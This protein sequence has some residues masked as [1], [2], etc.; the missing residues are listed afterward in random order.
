MIGSNAGEAVPTSSGATASI[1]EVSA[2]PAWPI[3]PRS[4]GK[5]S[6]QQGGLDELPVVHVRARLRDGQRAEPAAVAAVAV[7]DHHLAEPGAQAADDLARQL[8]QEL[9][10]ERD[11]DPEPYVVRAE[12]RP[13][14]G[15]DDR[16]GARERRRAQRDRL[17]EQRVGADGEVLAVLLERADGEDADRTRLPRSAASTRDSSLRRWPFIVS[18]SASRR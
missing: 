3:E 15:C 4:T 16:V 2:W 14:G 9:R 11:G 17:D 13:D 12:P 6:R 18:T 7:D 1:A 10:L 5:S 8:D